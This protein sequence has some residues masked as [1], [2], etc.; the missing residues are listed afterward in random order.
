MQRGS[1]SV[2]ARRRG[3]I[4]RAIA[5]I[6][7][8]RDARAVLTGRSGR[9]GLSSAKSEKCQRHHFSALWRRQLENGPN[10][11]EIKHL[12]VKA[13]NAHFSKFAVSATSFRELWKA[14]GISKLMI[15]VPLVDLK[16]P[17]ERPFVMRGLQIGGTKPRQFTRR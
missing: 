16:S 15:L 9:S 4:Q 17:K 3:S 1:P 6:I 7:L 12:Q 5:T 10:S 11:R 2:R 14:M 8:P 13:A